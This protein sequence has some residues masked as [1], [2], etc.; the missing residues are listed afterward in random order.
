MLTRV[1]QPTMQRYVHER[2]IEH[3]PQ[4]VDVR[5]NSLLVEATSISLCRIIWS[6]LETPLMQQ[7]LSE[8]GETDICA[9]SMK[10]ATI[11][12]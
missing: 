8:N 12:S 11:V 4:L 9:H 1:V 10:V 6:V 3:C 2:L 5:I 7:D